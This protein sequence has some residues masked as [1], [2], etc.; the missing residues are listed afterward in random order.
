MLPR[1]IPFNQIAFATLLGVAG[2]VYIYKPMFELPRQPESV[3]KTQ[4]VQ[5]NSENKGQD[6]NKQE[7]MANPATNATNSPATQESAAE[8]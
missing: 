3:K 1:R 6:R 7:D 4:A 2:G 5:T 8:K